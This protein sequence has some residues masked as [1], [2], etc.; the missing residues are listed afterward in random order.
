MGEHVWEV[1]WGIG[2]EKETKV[3]NDVCLGRK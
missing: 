1:E 2:G 3:G